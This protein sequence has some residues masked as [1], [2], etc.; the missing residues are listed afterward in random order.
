M[1]E[2]LLHRFCVKTKAREQELHQRF[3]ELWTAHAHLVKDVHELCQ[4]SIMVL[5]LCTS[6]VDLLEHNLH[7]HRTEAVQT[8]PR[9]EAL[10][11]GVSKSLK[12]I[13]TYLKYNKEQVL[14][15]FNLEG[16]RT[17]LHKMY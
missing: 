16:P 1:I 11:K 7:S 5:A 12:N 10:A 15:L 9:L 6:R 14:I 2:G 4:F 8:L 13:T 3:V 17:L